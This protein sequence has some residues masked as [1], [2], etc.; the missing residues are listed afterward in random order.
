METTIDYGSDYDGF[1][2]GKLCPLKAAEPPVLTIWNSDPEPDLAEALKAGVIK[3]RADGYPPRVEYI[4]G[5]C[6]GPRCVWWDADKERCAV[7]SLARKNDNTPACFWWSGPGLLYIMLGA[8]LSA[9]GRFGER[10]YRDTVR[11]KNTV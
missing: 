6:D 8:L 4:G 7:L 11:R 9:V 5:R 1:T 2:H 10:E 3:C